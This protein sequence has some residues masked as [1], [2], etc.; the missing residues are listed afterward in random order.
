M[1]TTAGK[2][3]Q[4]C[5][6]QGRHEP[7]RRRRPPW[8]RSHGAAS[9]KDNKQ[10]P[11]PRAARHGARPGVP[12]ALPGAGGH[13]EGFP[14]SLPPVVPYLGHGDGFPEVSSPGDA[15]APRGRAGQGHH[16]R[17]GS[18]RLWAG[19]E[20]RRQ[21][22]AGRRGD[23]AEEAQRGT[24]RQTARRSSLPGPVAPHRPPPSPAPR[25]SPSTGPMEPGSAFLPGRGPRRRRVPAAATASSC[26]PGHPG[27]GWWLPPL[28]SPPRG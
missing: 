23:E 3:A 1:A 14:K 9:L 7:P 10:D 15:E 20:P 17:H 22:T 18:G 6:A 8:G 25:G 21:E 5:P 26:L 2:S 24:A 4:P 19:R 16:H 12:A 27:Q 11:L 28:L 13:T